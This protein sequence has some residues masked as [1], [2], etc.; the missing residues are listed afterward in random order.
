MSMG[1]LWY[2]GMDAIQHLTLRVILYC[3]LCIPWN[4]ARFLDYAAERIGC[5]QNQLVDT[6]AKPHPFARRTSLTFWSP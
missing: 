2:G 4:Y 6:I 1:A 5:G 3:N